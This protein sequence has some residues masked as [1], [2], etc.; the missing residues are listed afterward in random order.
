MKGKYSLSRPMGYY[1]LVLFLLGSLLFAGLANPFPVQAQ[2]DNPNPPAQPVKLIFIHHSTGENWLRNGYGNLGRTLDANNYFVSDTNYGW[3][4]DG[5][6][7]RTDIPNWPEWFGPNRNEAALQALYNESGQNSADITRTLADPGGENTIIIFKSCFPNSELDGNPDDPPADE[8]DALTVAN[9]KRVYLELLDYFLSRP[10]K[11][12]VLVTAPPVSSSTY[13]KNARGLNN[14]LVNKW[15]QNYTGTNVFVFDFYTVLTGKNNHHRYVNGAIEYINN[16]GSNTSQYAT[17]GGDDHPNASGS[18][19]ATDEFVPLLNIFYNRWRADA[20][21]QP[22]VPSEGAQPTQGDTQPSEGQTTEGQSSIPAA[23]GTV[24]DFET[25]PSWQGWADETGTTIQ[26]AQDSSA[27]AAGSGSLRV[28]YNVKAGGWATCEHAYD[29]QQNWGSSEG[30][31]FRLHADTAGKNAIFYIHAGTPDATTPFESYFTTTDED[32]NAWRTVTIP[33]GGFN[34]APWAD[35]SGLQSFDP[36][37]VMSYGISLSAEGGDNTGTL[38]LDDVILFSGAPPAEPAAGD[39]E[40]QEAQ[41]EQEQQPADQA[42]DQEQSAEQPEKSSGKSGGL[43]CPG[44]AALIGVVA[45]VVLLR[46]K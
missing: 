6:G 15:L 19:K 12:F 29:A 21:S 36:T 24:D 40:Q 41:T 28:D 25:T 45:A 18:Q 13:A 10:D 1:A 31:S 30:I 39:T 3:G 11:M 26:C 38:W 27:A 2:G 9:A 32:V 16:T 8:G 14:W 33:W 37:L 4:P 5:I 34:R 42:Q 43:P 44:S 20:P 46:K 23:V 7:D 35:A 17:G 22:V